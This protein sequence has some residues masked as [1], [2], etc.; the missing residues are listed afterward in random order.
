MR[1]WKKVSINQMKLGL[2]GD[3]RSESLIRAVYDSL[4]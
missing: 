3:A 2:M 4:G 1:L